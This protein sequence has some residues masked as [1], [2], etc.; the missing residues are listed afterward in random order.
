MTRSNSGFSASHSGSSWV[1][2]ANGR[3]KKLERAVGVELRRSRGHPVGEFALGF[4]VPGKL[5]P[6]ILE[7][8]DIDREAGD[9]TRRQRHVDDPQHPPL[10][11]ND[12][13]LHARD[14]ISAARLRLRVA[15]AAALSSPSRVEELGRRV[16]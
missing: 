6:R 13:R 7:V 5:G 8:L 16:R 9:R 4:D 12:R 3:L 14:T 1:I 15:L 10:A 2:T 11:A